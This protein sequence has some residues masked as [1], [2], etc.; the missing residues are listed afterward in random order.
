MQMSEELLQL[1]GHRYSDF[2]VRLSLRR[3]TLIVTTRDAAMME[4]F[5]RVHRGERDVF[6]GEY[7]VD[8]VA[9]SLEGGVMKSGNPQSGI[10]T[11]V[12]ET[13]VSGS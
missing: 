11:F 5:V 3:N 9:Y 2:H 7:A 4:A 13:I 8:G 10:F 1:N 12:F 6:K